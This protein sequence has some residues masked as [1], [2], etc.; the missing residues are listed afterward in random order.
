[1]L[2]FLTLAGFLLLVA[3]I[4]WV[5]VKLDRSDAGK[6]IGKPKS[7]EIIECPRCGSSMYESEAMDGVCDECWGKAFDSASERAWRE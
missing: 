6:P 2:I 5:S 3:L 4:V 7:G 1:M